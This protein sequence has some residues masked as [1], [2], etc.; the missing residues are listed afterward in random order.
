MSKNEGRSPDTVEVQARF[1]QG[2]A[3]H[4]EGRLEKAQ[5]I[6]QEI[7][8]KMPDHVEALH[9]SG[10]IAL[11]TRDPQ[12]AFE[13]ISKAI[14]MDPGNAVALYHRGNALGDMNQHRAV[15]DSYDRAIALKPDFAEAHYN[16]GLALQDLKQ[17]QAAIGSYDRV[18]AIKG[19][20]AFVHYSR[21]N[22]LADLKQHQAAVDS[23]DRA[24]AL[25]ANFAEAHYNRGLALQELKRHQAAI[26]SYDR[27]IAIKPDLADAHYNRGNA[28]AELLQR[29]A[30]VESYDRAIALRPDYA[31][32]F[33][34]RAFVLQALGRHQEAIDGFTRALEL[35]PDYEYLPGALLYAK[36]QI[37]DW[38]DAD[39]QIARLAQQIDG[40]EKVAE[41]FPT[42]ALIDSP[43]SQHKAADLWVNDK[44][45]PNLELAPPPRRPRRKK[46]RLGYFSS[47]FRNHAVAYLLAEMI[48]KHDRDRFEVLAFSFG[49]G[50]E[51]ET[52]KRLAAAFDE[53]IDV[54]GQTDKAVAALSR[55][56]EVDIAV[57]LNGYTQHGRVGIFS[58][59]AAPLQ[60]NFLG[61]PGTM[62]ASYIDYLIADQ[63]LVPEAS[64]R[65]Y[66]EKIVYLPNSYQVN[67][68]KRR[69][70]DKAFT[71]DE[72]SLPRSGFVF[73]C[74]NNN[75]KITPA[76]FDSWMRMLN[77]LPRSVLW[78][79]EDNS[80]AAN[81]LRREAERRGIPGER[82]VFAGR[83][84][85]AEHLARHRAADLFIDT[86][87]Y[88]AHTTASDALWS[89]LPVLT[90]KGESFAGRVAAS[91]LNAV[92][93]PELITETKEEY[94]TLAVQLAEN[95][96]QLAQLRQKLERN[97][98]ATPLFDSG[99]YARHIEDAYSQM[100][101]RYQ[102]NLPP[103]HIH[104]TP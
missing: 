28:L 67:D 96:D 11:R 61:Y 70:A 85:H 86:L 43:L 17:H 87:P 98:L 47:D 6:F 22:A 69:I 79:M 42:L 63:T 16:R 84:P 18:I 21:G 103:D 76:T 36:R 10:V 54:V 34:N 53:F 91:L 26:E 62:G 73:C 94:E 37:C 97:R 14:E 56:R 8:E 101:E 30:A 89:G 35:K 81:N 7:L 68:R 95:P 58:Y 50:E 83:V 65:H 32:S 66:R 64:R 13:L 25:D 20:V 9:L 12:R 90:C 49:P 44:H 71:R 74:F 1:Q 4:R 102:S 77:R 88:N 19:D 57:D 55:A 27:A 104:V 3:F 75:Y 31:E 92:G 5:E 41:P 2:L 51:D 99:L 52:R 93:L 100:F 60:V 78:L 29:Q 38:S 82:L 72:L 23:Y 15:V 80:G 24:I 48:E 33:C 39:A 40:D 45:P 59:R 46:I